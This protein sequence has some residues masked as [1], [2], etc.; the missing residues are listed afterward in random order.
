MRR[1]GPGRMR[2]TRAWALAL[3]LASLI[4]IGA[5]AEDEEDQQVCLTCRDLV[6]QFGCRS[7][8]A[9]GLQSCPL[10]CATDAARWNGAGD[11]AGGDAVVSELVLRRVGRMLQSF[12]GSL[13]PPSKASLTNTTLSQVGSKGT[14][15]AVNGLV[16]GLGLSV[17]SGSWDT[18]E[19]GIRLDLQKLTEEENPAGA[20]GLMLRMMPIASAFFVT[21]F[22]S[23]V[24]SVIRAGTVFVSSCIPLMVPVV[25]K[26]VADKKLNVETFLGIGGALYAGALG[27]FA[28]IKNRKFGMMAQV[29]VDPGAEL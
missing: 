29:R 13:K 26:I 12:G 3:A 9:R 17:G 20:A 25:Q 15:Q 6:A 24:A 4:T 7:M 27:S 21:L 1:S 14:N 2:P 11:E 22:G 10:L 16:S 8:G 5:T 18:D 28:S 23:K 19:A